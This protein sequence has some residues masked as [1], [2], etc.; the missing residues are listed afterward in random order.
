MI[1]EL[2]L[3]SRRY[4]KSTDGNFAI[5]FAVVIGILALGAGVALDISNTISKKT[6]AQDNIDAAILAAA[7]LTFIDGQNE[8]EAQALVDKMLAPLTLQGGL[9][10]EPLN[11]IDSGYTLECTGIADSFI[12]G[13][14][15]KNELP[16][17]ITTSASVGVS[18]NIELSFVYDISNSMKR[19][20]LNALE[21]TLD[22][23]VSSDVF[24]RKDEKAVFSLI[25]FA[26]TV[27]FDM[28]YDKWLDPSRGLEHAPSFTGCFTRATTDITMPFTGDTLPE[29]ISAPEIAGN[30]VACPPQAMAAR[31]F[32]KERAPINSMI[33]GISTTFG[34]GTSDALTWGYRSLHPDMRGILTDS[35]TFP[36]DFST[37]NKKILIL[38]TDGQ[39][40]NKEWTREEK[41][42]GK[43]AADVGYEAF[44]E[45]C[46]YIEAQDEPI[47]I[48][49]VSLGNFL[50][51]SGNDL[52]G[53][54]T[55]CI[56]G[57]GQFVE[58]KSRTLSETINRILDAE[59][60]LRLSN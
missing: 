27:A 41:Q 45:T 56:R 36:R 6:N 5:M 44:V 3:V 26:N 12:P 47:D 23:L 48:W 40:F 25:P 13:V 1:N 53:A 37:D 42:P 24:E 14:T 15:G 28:S 38:L 34:T 58:A 22:Q 17:S 33:K 29:E 46:D 39:P 4:R 20:Q 2:K 32:N 11:A 31:F 60:N 52:R 7:K 55:D 57:N 21:E 43:Q 10:C 30:K 54:F 18:P 51:R 8:K 9:T 19:K 16:Y 50:S 49:V 59:K 35:A